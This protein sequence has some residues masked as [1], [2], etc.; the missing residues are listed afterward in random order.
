MLRFKKMLIIYD[1]I[2]AKQKCGA[3]SG[4]S[5]FLMNQLKF[6]STYLRIIC[7]T[8]YLYR[9]LTTRNERQS[10]VLSRARERARISIDE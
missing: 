9:H 4:G 10:S 2:N 8:L 7:S 5:L 3:A 1:N 6:L